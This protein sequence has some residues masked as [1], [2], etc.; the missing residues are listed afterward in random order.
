MSEEH[1]GDETR[2]LTVESISFRFFA[3]RSDTVTF[4]NDSLAW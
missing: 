3:C 4:A 2:L 1:L